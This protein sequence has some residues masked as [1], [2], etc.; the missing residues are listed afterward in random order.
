M[1]PF[2]LYDITA[3]IYTRSTERIISPM[4]AELYHLII[5]TEQGEVNREAFAALERTAEELA[6][7]AEELASIA[8]RLADESEDEMLKQKMVPA[9]ESLLISGKNILLVAQ[10]LHIQPDADNCIEELALCAK[11]IIMETVKVLQIEDDAVVRKII[12]S[13]HWLL[14]C[15]LM[16]E[17]AEVISAMLAAFH[18]FSE[19]LLLLTNLTERFLWDL[20]ESP[21]Q[22]H[23]AQS[24]KILKN[25]IPMLHTAKLSNL[26]HPSDHQLKQSNNYIFDLAKNTAKEL[27]SLLSNNVGTKKQHNRSGVFSQHLHKL[28]SFLSSPQVI[29]LQE[30]KLNSLVEALVS[31]CMRLAD[32]SR[33]AQKLKLVKFCHCLLKFRKAIAMHV[34]TPKGFPMKTQVEESTK[35]KCSAMKVELE[36]LNQAVCTAIFYQILDNFVDAKGPLKRLVEAAVEPCVSAEKGEFLRKLKPLI[37][38]FF[39]HSNQMLNTASLVLGT[40][41]EMET[42]QDIEDGVDLMRR[43]LAKVPA[44]LS[45]RSH[46]PADHYV[47]EKLHFLCQMWSSTIESLLMCLEKVI[48]LREFLDLSVQELIAHKEKSEK[49]LDD[50]NSG[51]FSCSAFKLSKQA[52]Q[53]V[54]FASRHVDRARDPI[55]R[56]GLLVL[57]KHLENTMLHVK[58]ATDRCMGNINCLQAKSEYSKK[59]KELIESARSVRMG[60]DECNQP[61]ILSPLRE[62]IRNHNISKDFPRCFTPQNPTGLVE[63]NAIKQSHSNNLQSM[64]ESTAKHF[65]ATRPS[66]LSPR[67][68][69]VLP[70][71]TSE[72]ADLHPLIREL[73]LATETQN[74]TRL[75]S[76]CSD[77]FEFSNYCTEAAKE[78]LSVAK[79]PVSEKLLHYREIVALIPCFISLAKEVAPDP[80]SSPDKLF[81]IADLLSEKLDEAKQCL[82]TVASPWYKLAKQLFCITSPSDCLDSNQVIEEIMEILGTIVQLVSKAT[83]SKSE[84]ILEFSRRHEAFLRVLAKFSSVETRTKCLLEKALAVNKPHSDSAKLQNFDANCILWSVTIQAFLNS[85]D[86]FIGRDVLSLSDLQTKHRISWQSTLAAVSESSLRIREATRLSLLSNTDHSDKNEIIML[87]EQMKILT[88][89][90]L[91]VADVLSA[92]SSPAPNLSA[93]FELLQRELA[94]TAKVLLGRLNTVNGEYVSRIQNIVRQTRLMPCGNEGDSNIIDNVALGENANQLIASIQIVKQIIRDAP[95][96][97]SS[98]EAKES[99]LST[100]DHLLLLTDEVVRKT[101]KL[102]SQLDKEH[103]LT[104][105]ILYEWSAKAGY[106]VSQL[107]STKGISETDL[108]QVRK[109]LQN[110]EEYSKSSQPIWK[111]QFC[112]QKEEESR[113]HQDVMSPKCKTTKTSQG[114]SFA[115]DASKKYQGELQSGFQPSHSAH[116]L[117]P[118]WQHDNCPVSQVAKQLTT[119]VSYMAQFLKRKGPITTKEQLIDC[120]RQI[121]SGGHVLMNFATIIAKNCLDKRCASELLY[122]MEQTKTVSYQLSIISRVNASTGTSRSSA[123]HLV[124]NAQN[125]VQVTLQMLKAAEA[126]CVKGLQ[127]PTPNSEEVSV[128]AF[129][130]QWRKSLWWHRVKAA[131]DSERDELGLRKTGSWREPTFTSMTQE[132]CVP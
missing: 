119:N 47:P 102:Q 29:D 24:L 84:K 57:V 25:C 7:A 66:Q 28:S 58:V 89:S 68:S 34:N 38:I 122:A 5:A 35:E 59:A 82:T 121:I 13:A 11:R 79:S 16:L 81:Q 67:D 42:I 27:I 80:I 26:K 117:R 8:K 116:N 65:P 110:M 105:S 10:K 124:S 45:E 94:L 95:E 9:A 91:Q 46:H 115:G 62:N 60:L 17:A 92:S 118:K 100:V 55:F 104:D 50:Q 20:K 54:E 129:C 83:H 125:L 88:E 112:L 63:Q 12:Q 114:A 73:I 72:K 14:D 113:R 132:L 75:N 1:E 19:A 2:S 49:A 43:L 48:D 109:C 98:L 51:D 90:L 6:K 126:A 70:E 74:I 64:E 31:Y 93:H 127:E 18:S 87:R 41:T 22:V 53:V 4:V 128:A 44:I 86:Q 30:G 78:A 71:V 97:S 99:L 108:E 85:V 131:L 107:Y 3:V 101:R 103:L 123:E 76:A 77:L 61:D 33:P 37:A 120:A 40:C 36:N 96:N 52:T 23:L 32:S 21:H 39:S 106:L 130:S 111:T 15:L 69:I 56:N